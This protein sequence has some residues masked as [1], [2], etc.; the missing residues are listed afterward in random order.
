MANRK[1][2]VICKP[3]C[4]SDHFELEVKPGQ[5]ILVKYRITPEGN[6][7]YGYSTSTSYSMIENLSEATL[8]E[9]AKSQPT[10]TD[11]RKVFEISHHYSSEHRSL[12]EHLLIQ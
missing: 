8:K 10:K 2:L 6:G 4:D 3:L 9:R 1:N 7:S 5:E 11:Q 12:C